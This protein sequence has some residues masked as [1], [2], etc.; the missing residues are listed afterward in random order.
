MKASVAG[1]IFCR[2]ARFNLTVLTLL[3]LFAVRRWEKM[4]MDEGWR[5]EL[6]GVADRLLVA[7][8]VSPSEL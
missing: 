6:E 7:L 3:S 4:E 1:V 5:E 8:Q 2:L